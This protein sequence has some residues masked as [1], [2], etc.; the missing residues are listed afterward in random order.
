MRNRWN[1][2]NSTV[3]HRWWYGYT[4]ISIYRYIDISIYRHIDTSMILSLTVYAYRTPYYS[5]E[6]KVPPW[7][8]G[9][10]APTPHPSTIHHHHHRPPGAANPTR[11]G[12]AAP[13]GRWLGGGGSPTMHLKNG[14][15]V[16]DSSG[17]GGRGHFAFG[18]LF[19]D[20]KCESYFPH[21]AGFLPT[22]N[23]EMQSVIPV[24]S[25]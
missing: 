3:L 12:F 15:G 4:D 13:G 11:V 5:L 6:Q 1:S 7:G 2:L 22:Q 21:I 8:V 25:R 17:F 16:P 9:G 20:S 10:G 24:L 18:R 14:V 19:S 23:Q